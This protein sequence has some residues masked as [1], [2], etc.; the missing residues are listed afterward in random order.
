MI[1]RNYRLV[2]WLVVLG[3]AGRPAQAQDTR[4]SG[5]AFLRIGVNAAALAM[6]DA[7]VAAS[8]DAF[9]TF[10]NPAGLAVM[11]TNSAAA[12]HR[13]WIGDLRTYDLAARFR[14]GPRGGLGLAVTAV[15]SGDLEA[16]DLTG[17]PAGVFSAQFVS[18]GLSYGR[19][20]GPLQAGATV[21]YL[22]ERIF[23]ESASGYAVDLGLQLALLDGGLRL[24]GALQNLGEMSDLATEAT[25]L[26]LTVRVGAAAYPFHLIATDDGGAVLGAMLV[27]EVSHLFPS[28]MTRFHAGLGV[29]VMELL[30]L[31]SGLLTND[32]ARKLTFG[33]GLR[34]ER[35]VFDYAFV[36][37]ETGFG[38]GHVLTLHYHW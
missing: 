38:T 23:D 13:I 2:L 16:F 19:R 22:S 11:P 8:Q 14:V 33:G 36:P 3:A 6:G 21:K 25:E 7:G 9:S 24:G 28:E 35:L 17:E 15:D 1:G 31:R 30:V 26:P 37:F 27:A 4:D 32:G 12:S 29:E 20:L 18:V 10:W 34:Y 5:L